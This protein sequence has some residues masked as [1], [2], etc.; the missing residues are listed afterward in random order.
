MSLDDTK[1]AADREAA[2]N[3]HAEPRPG[4]LE[5]RAT[6]PMATGRDLSRAYS[7]GVAEPCLDIAADPALARR[8]TA[9]GNLVAVVSNGT[10]VLGLGNIGAQASKP[11]MEG[12]AVLFKKFAGIDCFDIEVD[13]TDPERLADLVCRLEPTFGA[14]NLE[15]IKAPDCF[16]VEKICR[17]R[18]GIPV[19]HDDQHG[20]AIVAA[21][22]ASN[23]LRIT[24]KRFE[25]IR[26]VALGA[27]A[28]GI[29][30]LKMLMVM[31]ARTEHIT[32]IDSKG[33]VHDGREDLT[34]EKAEFARR[35]EMRSTMDAM[36]GADL[37]LGVS[38]P[39]LLTPEMVARMA[40]DPIV[41]ALANPVPEIMPEAARAAAPG[42]LIA[43]GRSD[44]P[45]QVNNVLCFSF[46]FRGALDAG[47][48][49]INDEMKIACVEAI[50]GLARAPASAELGAAYQGERLSFG[51]DYLIP[52]PF[53]PRLLP[54]VATAVARAAIESGVAT[55]DLDLDAYAAGLR[56][57]VHRSSLVMRPVFEAA[58]SAGRRIVFAEGEEPRVLRAVQ[59]MREEGMARPILV[60]RPEVV[61]AR[62]EREGLSLQPGE[63]FDLVNPESDERYR[64]YWGSYHAIMSRRGVSPDLAKAILRTNSTAI[65]AVMVHRGEADSLIC[66]TVG[67]YSWHLKYVSEVL[68]RDHLQPVGAMS[69]ILLDRG[70]LFVADTHVHLEPDAG[71]IA[72]VMIASARHARRFGLAPKVALCS[73]S[74]FGSLDSRAAR[75]ARDAIALLDAQGADFEYEGEMHTDA[76]LDPDL[77]ERLL[78]GNRLRGRANILVY[79]GAEPAGAARNLLKSVADGIEVGPVLMGMGNRAHI[80]TPGVTVRGLLNI[81]ALA[82]TPVESYG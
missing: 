79:A 57:Q 56:G 20:T 82:A 64:D 52:K 66:G 29:A 80:V 50:A 26:I 28:A 74:Q 15:D 8:Y 65:A 11:V 37:F 6:K 72:Q 49:T 55:R 53:D 75:A 19:F 73:G 45:N 17:E 7:P 33:V 5:I 43:T 31:G 23:A 14:I 35:T 81:S 16:I 21:A 32:M 48:T 18:M 71:Q 67:A 46:I 61:A 30:C 42:A 54:T 58:R 47:A 69:L 39:G 68:A 4:K 63:A 10:A 41:F 22:A 59:A 78:P 9:K 70:P 38:G 51:P 1:I 34:P 40:P 25:E 3:Y 12:K 27:G 2:L 24:G 36:E 13:E 77:R 44:Y 76:A 60:G 62:I